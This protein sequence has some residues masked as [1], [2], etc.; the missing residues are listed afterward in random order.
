MSKY[1]RKEDK[2]ENLSYSEELAQQQP[3]AEPEPQDA[4]EASFKKRYGDLR[5]HIP[6]F[7]GSKKMKRSKS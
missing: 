4:E 1:K 5:R 7:N 2:E 3:Q 6:K